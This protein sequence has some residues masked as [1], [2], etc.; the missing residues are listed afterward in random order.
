[1]ATFDHN[2]VEASV[3]FIKSF[4][5]LKDEY[6]ANPISDGYSFK[7]LMDGWYLRM[8][9]F[10]QVSL[11][12]NE[13]DMSSGEDTYFDGHPSTMALILRDYL[14]MLFD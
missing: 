12:H 13:L 9:H 10:G 6:K 7:E 8:N 3:E 1:M 5:E 4:V 2:I 14:A 11:H